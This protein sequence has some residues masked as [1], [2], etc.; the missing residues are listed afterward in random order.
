[1][2]ARRFVVL[3]T[4]ALVLTGS[5]LAASAATNPLSLVLQRSDLPAK[6]R[7]TNG[8]LPTVERALARAGISNSAAFFLS[9]QQLSA[10][11]YETVSGLVIVTK[12]AG[13]ARKTYRLTKADLAPKRG[14]VVRLAAYGD[15]QVAM[16][17]KTVGKAELLVRKGSVVWQLEVDPEG[18]TKSQTL[19]KLRT[20]AAKQKRR[21]RAG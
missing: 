11:R 2:R 13:D 4:A 17:T 18:L 3:L 7:Y 6:A 20:Y 10:T 9:T 16:W 5:A 1:M 8:R 14:G 12:S 19:G 15:E 21:I